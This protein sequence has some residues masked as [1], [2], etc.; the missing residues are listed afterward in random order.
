MSILDKLAYALDRS[1]EGPNVELAK[2]IAQ[3]NDSK[4]VK[5]LVE[6]LA[7]K[8]KDIQHDC[9]KVLYETGE[10]KPALIVPYV[11]EFTALLESKNNRMQWGGMAALSAI[12]PAYPK[13][14][15]GVLAKIVDAADK[16]T[17]ITK[18]NC[19]NILISL[20]SVKQYAD[21]AFSLL[22]EQ[23]QGS[24][25]NQLPMYA[26]RAMPII[27]EKTKAKFIKTLSS[28]LGDI[29]KDTKR[30]RVEMVLKKLS[31]K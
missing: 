21:S 3:K 27:T 10:R 28:R 17:V 8:K 9:I 6:N 24:P 14:I 12:A 31:K 11:K 20:C 7:N 18:D 25:T 4:A 1:D 22:I 13:E 15:Y 26:E 2:S 23:L 29:E 5:E 16:G 19:V 30:K